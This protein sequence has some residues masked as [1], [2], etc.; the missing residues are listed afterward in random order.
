MSG[1]RTLGPDAGFRT[2]V[3]AFPMPTVSGR[4]QLPEHVRAKIRE[5]TRHA[6]ATIARDLR[7]LAS[8]TG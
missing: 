1:F 3:R 4:V 5:L 7:A 6:W 2:H 8:A